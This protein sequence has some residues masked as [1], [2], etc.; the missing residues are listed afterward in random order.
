MPADAARRRGPDAGRSFNPDRYTELMPAIGPGA[1]AKL[2]LLFLTIGGDD[3]L[4]EAYGD[5]RKYLDQKGVKYVWSELPGYG[6]EWPFWRINL[7]DFSEKIFQ[8]AAR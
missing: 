2:H 8:G 7:V 6:H 5:L 3:G 1:H 4:L